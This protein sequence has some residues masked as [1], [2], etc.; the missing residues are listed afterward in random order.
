V[1]FRILLSL[2]L[3]CTL[4]ACVSETPTPA[5]NPMAQSSSISVATP[6]FITSPDTVLRWYSD[7]IWID[8]PEGRFER[9][10]D[11]LQASLQNEFA[12]KGY[13]FVGKDE[14]ANYDVL[15]V[16]ILGDIAGHEKL[17]QIFRLYPSL[18]GAAGGYSR[19]TVL[20]ALAPAGTKNIVWRGA[21]EIFT[22]PELQPISVRK[23]RMEWGAMQVLASIPNYP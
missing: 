2:I 5:P 19:G 8:D 20:V 4:S 23:Q 16:A 6:E 10:A 3:G 12:R 11:M 14:P 15:A 17:E 18:N 21:L 9:R 1:T 22:D 7:L 13:T